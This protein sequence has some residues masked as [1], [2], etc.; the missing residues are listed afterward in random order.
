MIPLAG[1]ILREQ[2][3]EWTIRRPRYRPLE[4]IASVATR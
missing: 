1:A 2:S 3:D 4:T